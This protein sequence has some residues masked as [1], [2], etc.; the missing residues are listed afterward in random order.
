MVET[1]ICKRLAVTPAGLRLLARVVAGREPR[2][3]GNAGSAAG[4]LI[5]NGMIV[6]TGP[7]RGHYAATDKGRYV[8]SAARRLGW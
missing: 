7:Y 1:E 6:E 4:P 5:R 8:V 3:R 2:G